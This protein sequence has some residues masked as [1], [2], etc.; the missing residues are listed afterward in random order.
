MENRSPVFPEVRL[1]VS[2]NPGDHSSE[3]RLPRSFG[4][5]NPR[6][7]VGWYSRRKWRP[8]GSDTGTAAVIESDTGYPFENGNMVEKEDEQ[9]RIAVEGNPENQRPTEVAELYE[10]HRKRLQEAEN[11]KKIIPFR[12]RT[13]MKLDNGER[14]I[15]RLQ[16]AELRRQCQPGRSLQKDEETET[17]EKRN[18]AQGGNIQ[19]Y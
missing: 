13:G 11:R 8:L 17:G 16:V 9:R 2:G 4:G 10:E 14:I 6:E 15:L 7:K 18:I 12:R 1:G 5:G 3:C 19:K